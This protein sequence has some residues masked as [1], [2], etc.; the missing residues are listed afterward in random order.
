MEEKEKT[1]EDVNLRI[2]NK[3]YYTF[4]VCNKS[5]IKILYNSPKKLFG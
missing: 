4:L 1:N 5:T 3:N 2:I